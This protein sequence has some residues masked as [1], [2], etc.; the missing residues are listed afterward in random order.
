MTLAKNSS[1]S[2]CGTPLS[3]VFIKEGISKLHVV[4]NFW[5]SPIELELFSCRLKE[6][7]I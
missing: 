2:T 3:T 4:N 6:S 1:Q 7:K 5:V